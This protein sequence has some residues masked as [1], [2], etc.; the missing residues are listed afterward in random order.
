M[1]WEHLA[2]ALSSW[3]GRSLSTNRSMSV[4]EMKESPWVRGIRGFTSASASPKARVAASRQ[5]RQAVPTIPVF[6]MGVLLF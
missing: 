4:T 1:E 3:R 5:P 2:A 6:D